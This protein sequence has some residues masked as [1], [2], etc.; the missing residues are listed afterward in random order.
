ETH[1]AEFGRGWHDQERMRL[2]LAREVR[3]SLGAEVAKEAGAPELGFPGAHV[4][5]ANLEHGHAVPRLP[6]FGPRPGDL[7]L[8]TPVGRAPDE[9]VDA[10]GE[11]EEHGARS[12]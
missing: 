10:R 4:E 6:W 3:R 2:R 12:R 11:R 8:G 1:T 5:M 7:E 9:R